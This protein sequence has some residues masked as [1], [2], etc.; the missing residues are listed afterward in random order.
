LLSSEIVFSRK[1]PLAPRPKGA[2]G[3]SP[4]QSNNAERPTEKTNRAAWPSCDA[5]LFLAL[6]PSAVDCNTAE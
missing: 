5:A 6:S 1:N 4:F 3:V 2:A